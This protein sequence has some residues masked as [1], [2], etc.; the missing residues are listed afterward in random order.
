MFVQ[1]SEQI[2]KELGCQKI[3]SDSIASFTSAALDFQ[4]FPYTQ[5]K[6]IAFPKQTG[7]LLQSIYML[8]DEM[9]KEKKI[10][11]SD[12]KTIEVQKIE[13]LFLDANCVIERR[14]I[15]YELTILLGC[16]QLSRLI[17][18][19]NEELNKAQYDRLLCALDMLEVC[20]RHANEPYYQLACVNKICIII[21]LSGCVRYTSMEGEFIKFLNISK[22]QSELNHEQLVEWKNLV[23]QMIDTITVNISTKEKQQQFVNKTNQLIKLY[24]HRDQLGNVFN[25]LIPG[26]LDKLDNEMLFNVLRDVVSLLDDQE[27]QCSES[28]NTTNLLKNIKDSKLLV[29]NNANKLVGFCI[30]FCC[31]LINFNAP[32]SVIF[33]T[34]DK[35]LLNLFM[36]LSDF[37]ISDQLFGESNKLLQYNCVKECIEKAVKAKMPGAIELETVLKKVLTPGGGYIE[38]SIANHTQAVREFFSESMRHAFDTLDV[39]KYKFQAPEVVCLPRYGRLFF[40]AN[41][42][43]NNNLEVYA[44]GERGSFINSNTITTRG[45]SWN[46]MNIAATRI[47][48]PDENKPMDNLLFYHQHGGTDEKKCFLGVIDENSKQLYLTPVGI[49]KHKGEDNKMIEMTSFCVLSGNDPGSKDLWCISQSEIDFRNFVTVAKV[50]ASKFPFIKSNLPE[51]GA[52]LKANLK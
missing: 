5:I 52:T 7:R 15:K 23:G 43:P 9:R 1:K 28:E 29:S 38:P 21:K 51:V 24:R 50:D 49:G 18:T 12:I 14:E 20:Y 34:K 13:N 35:N 10:K 37:A 41:S 8:I 33:N 16:H 19:D 11:S 30:G 44:T 2:N 46:V 42:F 39:Q 6:T 40:P 47:R 3:I 48:N 32:C 27:F 22:T 4:K 25:Y 17:E 26:D 36:L 31:R 45:E